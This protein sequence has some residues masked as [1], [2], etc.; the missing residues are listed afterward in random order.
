MGERGSFVRECLRERERKF[1][2]QSEIMIIEERQSQSGRHKP[3]ANEMGA[4]CR[5]SKRVF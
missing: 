1:T 3:R 4:I 2:S 5:G